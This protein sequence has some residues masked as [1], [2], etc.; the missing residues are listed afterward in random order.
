MNSLSSFFKKH[1]NGFLF[2]LQSQLVI[3]FVIL[4]SVCFPLFNIWRAFFGVSFTFYVFLFFFFSLFSL[5]F[6]FLTFPKLFHTISTGLFCDFFWKNHT[7]VSFG[8]MMMKE[9]PFVFGV[10]ASSSFM[11]FYLMKDYPT[12]WVCYLFYVNCVIFRNIFLIPFLGYSLVVKINEKKKELSA[13]KGCVETFP[14][15]SNT[16]LLDNQEFCDNFQNWADLVSKLKPSA[17]SS[18]KISFVTVPT[19]VFWHFFS[20]AKRIGGVIMKSVFRNKKE[21]DSRLFPILHNEDLTIPQ[22]ELFKKLALRI[23]AYSRIY[24]KKVQSYQEHEMGSVKAGIFFTVNPTEKKELFAFSFALLRDSFDLACCFDSK[25]H[26]SESHKLLLRLTKRYLPESLP[27]VTQELRVISGDFAS[28]KT[29]H[30]PLK[31]EGETKIF[32]P[33]EDRF[34]VFSVLN[35]RFFF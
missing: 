32:T 33:K 19:S 4:Y 34:E 11:S 7:V 9:L 14:L 20:E 8:A 5:F 27:Q 13:E 35:T 16:Q 25:L 3:S 15:F 30:V 6:L 2:H 12:S 31:C 17:D 1:W 23:T 28:E 22:A 18:K 29:D 10:Y 26:T 21:I 24:E